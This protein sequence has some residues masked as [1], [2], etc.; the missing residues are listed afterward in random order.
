M[1]VISLKD[2]HDKLSEVL[3][4]QCEILEKLNGN[5]LDRQTDKDWYS[6][7]EVAGIIGKAP[8]T[9]REHARYKRIRAMKRATGRGKSLEWMVSHA[10]VQRIRNEGLLPIPQ[11]TQ[12]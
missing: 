7:E 6:I 9:V 11:L 8:Y 2:V 5:P 4:T 12:A 1:S 3:K 10:E